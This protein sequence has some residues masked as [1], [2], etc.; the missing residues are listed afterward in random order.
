MEKQQEP[1]QIWL[2]EDPLGA[3]EKKKQASA[4]PKYGK[5]MA[6]AHLDK[7]KTTLKRKSDIKLI[8]EVEEIDEEYKEDVNNK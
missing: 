4:N 5:V 8:N 1:H 6:L 2:W 7:L 3:H